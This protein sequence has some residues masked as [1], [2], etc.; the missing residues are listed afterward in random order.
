MTFDEVLEIRDRNSLS[1]RR[2]LMEL[3]AAGKITTKESNRFKI[4]NAARNNGLTVEEYYRRSRENTARHLDMTPAE[5][6]QHC[7]H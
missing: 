7:S 2:T 3:V 4:E 6:K 1:L 5:Y